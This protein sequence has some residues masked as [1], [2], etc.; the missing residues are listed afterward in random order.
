MRRNGRRRPLTGLVKRNDLDTFQK[1]IK[2]AHRHNVTRQVSR[3][4]ICVEAFIIPTF[5]LRYIHFSPDA[6]FVELHLLV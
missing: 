1:A 4:F 5:L 6:A 3:I 2:R